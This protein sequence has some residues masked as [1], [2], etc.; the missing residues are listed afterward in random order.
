MVSPIDISEMPL[1]VTI[2]PAYAISVSTLLNPSLIYILPILTSS[3]DPSLLE[4][5]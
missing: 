3:R 4:S 2:S 1:N 5:K